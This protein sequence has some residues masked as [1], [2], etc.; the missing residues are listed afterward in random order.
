MSR[1][2]SSP[3][4]RAG[5]SGALLA[6][7]LMTVSG[8]AYMPRQNLVQ[9]PTSSPPQPA[10]VPIA[11]GSIYQANYTR[12]LFEDRR[13]RGIGDLLTVVLNERVNAAKNSEANAGRSGAGGLTIKGVPRGLEGVVNDSLNTD[14]SG[15]SDFNGKGGATANNSVT[16]TITTT[17]KAVLPNGNLQVVGEKQIGINQG[18][19]YIRFS[20]VVNPRFITTANT[21]QSTQ[22]GDA[23]LEYYGD[24]YIDEAQRMGWLQR[25][26]LNVSPF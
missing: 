9:G 12:P 16:G 14:I 24:G 26:F 19:E 10:P 1:S 11:N 23:R 7:L 15:K 13:A 18:A 17:V 25:F 5:L 3:F 2:L 4:K 8:C 6:T 22:V 20:G 21:I